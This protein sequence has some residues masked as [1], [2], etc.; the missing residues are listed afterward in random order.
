[1]THIWVPKIKILEAELTPTKLGVC[2]EYTIKKYKVGVK[3]PVQVVGPFKNLITDWG[4]DRI[5][6]G[7]LNSSY[8]YIGAGTATP[9]VGDLQLANGS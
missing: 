5:G 3:E 9:T 7:T 6:S 4:M 8:I 1:M 2:G